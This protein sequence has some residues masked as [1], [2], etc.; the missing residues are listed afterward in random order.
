M[1][2]T[3]HPPVI[4]HYMGVKRHNCHIPES[5]EVTVSTVG[6]KPDTTISLASSQADDKTNFG[7]FSLFSFPLV[8]TQVIE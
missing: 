2:F 3:S 1:P 7:F 4:Y 5:L 8:L 6:N